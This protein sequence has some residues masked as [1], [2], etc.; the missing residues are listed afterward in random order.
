[1]MSSPVA[2]EAGVVLPEPAPGEVWTVGAVVVNG[3]GEAFAQRRS[4]DRPLF[5]G[6][7]D[8]VGGHVE[9][10]ETLVDALAREVREETGWR[11]TRLRRLLRV[12]TWEGDDGRGVRH[13]ADYLV[14][15]AGEPSAPA[16]RPAEHS[17]HRW[18]A[19]AN[20]PE[21]LASGHPVD[22]YV[23]GL[24]A[25]ALDATAAASE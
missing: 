14:E 5:P 25:L 7:W 22:A 6:C 8:V 9:P 24:L 13:E 23:H 10:G 12:D 15:V 4:A 2:V 16:Q 3:R 11:L 20:L 1:M 17:G 21:L 18:F 19:P